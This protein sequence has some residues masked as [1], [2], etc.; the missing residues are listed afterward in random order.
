MLK[1]SLF[2][3]ESVISLKSIDILLKKVYTSKEVGVDDAEAP[4]VPMPNTEVKL[5]RAEDT[6]REAARENR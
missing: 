2:S 1:I 3:F 4:P 6:W 5:C